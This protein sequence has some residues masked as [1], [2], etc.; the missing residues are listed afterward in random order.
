MSEAGVQYRKYINAVL[1][2]VAAPDDAAFPVTEPDILGPFYLAGAPF[3]QNIVPSDYHKLAAEPLVIS[4]NVY[5]LSSDGSASPAVGLVLD[6]WQADADGVYDNQDWP[7]PQTA[8]AGHVYRFR[9]KQT[10]PADGHYE[11]TTV[12]PGHY[13]IGND[14]S[15]TKEYRTSHVHLR[16]WDDDELLLTTQLYFPHDV[17]NKQDHWYSINRQI[18]DELITTEVAVSLVGT[19]NIVVA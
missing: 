15:G 10:V 9:G 3:L 7:D 6:F 2:P 13:F 11:L 5:V 14:A 8:P 4:G 17:W 18:S 1:P 12:K 19:Y 16:V